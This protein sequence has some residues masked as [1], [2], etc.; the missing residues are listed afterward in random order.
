MKRVLIANRG[1][2]AVRIIR[3]CREMKIE[4]VAI[5]STEDADS[6]HVK[7]AT[8]AVC[9]G[10]APSA[11]SYLNI[12]NIISAAKE[13]NCD[14]VHPGFGFL[15]ENAH[16]AET[17]ERCG[18]TFIGPSAEAIRMMGDK[19]RAREIMINGGVPVVPGS[20]GE[21]E[22]VA[23]ARKVAKEIG[24]PV[25]IKASAGG[26]GRGMR[27]ANSSKELESAYANAKQEALSCFGNDGVYI[28]KYIVNPKHIEIQILA[29]KFGNVIHLGE[30]EC[31]IQ[32]RNQKMIEEAPSKVITQS[33]RNKMG[34]DAVRAAMSVG[35]TNAGTM[36]FVVD[37]DGNYYFIEM[38]TRIQVEHAVT[39]MVTDID[40]VR[41]QIRIASGLPLSYTQKD[42]RINGHAIECRIN[43]E[44]VYKNFMPSPGTVEFLHFPGGYNVRVDTA[45]YS[46]CRISPHYDS[47][48]A[49]IIVKGKTR[50][51]AINRMRRAL[52]EVLVDG[53]KTNSD[54]LYLILHSID[55]TKGR[56]DTGFIEKYR[57]ELLSV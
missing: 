21:V 23:A 53:V 38:N 44:D 31:S 30:R 27:I 1:E 57:E 8:R 15:S 9:V 43:A 3:A 4:T 20:P 6:L 19:A 45:L 46:G 54:F 49:K 22:S 18:I 39:E 40:I 51:D 48:I 32:R 50:I 2:I 13:T 29:D 52:E 55:F 25:L 5:Y 7:L 10:P 41:E 14:A 36:E 24:Y 35:Y 26:G 11:E 42:V 33:L 12:Q 37:K 34:S 17:L 56:Y 47:M 16:F 28:E